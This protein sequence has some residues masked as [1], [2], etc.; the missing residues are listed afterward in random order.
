MK[1]LRNSPDLFNELKED[2]NRYCFGIMK[3][4]GEQV[5]EIKGENRDIIALFFSGIPDVFIQTIMN[6]VS[7]GS[8]RTLRYRLRQ[9]IKDASCP[10]ENLFL[11]MLSI[12]KQPGKKSKE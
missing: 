9:T 4:L 7:I 3:K 5:P 2:L 11:E 8:L 10:D 6:R 12:E 1:E